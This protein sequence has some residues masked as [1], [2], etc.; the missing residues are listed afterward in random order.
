M[1]LSAALVATPISQSSLAELEAD[2]E[3]LHIVILLIPQ[4]ISH[5]G[6]P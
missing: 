1:S 5:L 6:R 3:I 4:P 2:I